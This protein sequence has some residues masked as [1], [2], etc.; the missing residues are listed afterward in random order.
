M[1][2]PALTDFPYRSP[3]F[4]PGQHVSDGNTGQGDGGDRRKQVIREKSGP[5]RITNPLFS[6]HVLIRFLRMVYHFHIPSVYH[7]AADGQV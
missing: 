6:R 2:I 1:N 4:S 7:D 5:A 3:A